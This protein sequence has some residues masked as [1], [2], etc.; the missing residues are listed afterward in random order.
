MHIK[1][2]LLVYQPTNQ[3]AQ[4]MWYKQPD[5]IIFQTR[6]QSLQWH[7]F[8]SKQRRPAVFSTA[9]FHY[10]FNGIPFGLK[11]AATWAKFHTFGWTYAHRSSS[12]TFICKVTYTY[13]LHS[14]SKIVSPWRW[15]TVEF[16]TVVNYLEKTAQAKQK[17]VWDSAW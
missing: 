3:T 7:N 11:G 16:C 6:V 2:I 4:V 8:S 15:I 12:R 13:C 10:E 1:L 17:K 9:R 5:E 14:C